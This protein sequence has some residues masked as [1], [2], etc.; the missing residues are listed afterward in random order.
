MA[1]FTINRTNSHPGFGWTIYRV[2]PTKRLEDNLVWLGDTHVQAEAYVELLNRLNSR[3]PSNL[4][5]AT[6]AGITILLTAFV[7]WSL[8]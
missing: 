8:T 1:L 5:I 6:L 3:A 7:I 4:M 2:D